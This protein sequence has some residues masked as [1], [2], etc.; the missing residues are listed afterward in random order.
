[1]VRLLSVVAAI[2]LLIGISALAVERFDDRE[3]FVP[4]PDAVAEGFVREL[5]A[6]RWARARPYLTEPLGDEEL[7]AMQEAL[8]ARVGE[9]TEIEAKTISHD[10]RNALA[11]VR[12]SSKQ[13]SEAIAYELRFEAEWKIV[14]RGGTSTN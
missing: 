8:E 6:K 1:M 10:D 12:L 14:M 11:N 5:L 3:T 13:G 2:A 4:P 7:R 9:P